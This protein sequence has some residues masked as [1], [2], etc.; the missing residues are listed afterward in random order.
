VVSLKE[1]TLVAK[2][3]GVDVS[4][5]ITCNPV[6]GE[7]SS[8][9]LFGAL[10][11]R[12]GNSTTDSSFSFPGEPTWTCTGSPQDI[13]VIATVTSPRKPFKTGPALLNLSVVL[14]NIGGTQI[15]LGNFPIQEIQIR[16]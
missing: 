3:A 15:D 4:V 2:G 13:D 14:S 7:G 11:Q 6:F 16:H 12:A 5:Q 9:A 10:T 1:A 8:L